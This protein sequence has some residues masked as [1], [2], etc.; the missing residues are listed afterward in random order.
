MTFPG[1]HRLFLSLIAGLSIGTVLA[2]TLKAADQPPNIVFFF[3][4]DQ[5]P[6]TLGCY[7][8]SIIQTPNIDALAAR[9]TR[10]DNAFVSQSICWVSRTTI[11]TGLTGRSYGT[12]GN[13]DLARADAVETFYTDILRQNGYRTGQFGK[14]HAKMAKGFIREAHFDEFEF[15]DR[16]PYFKTL[17]DGSLRHETDLVVDRGIDFVKRQ[18]DGQPFALNLWFNA[19]HAEDSDRRTAFG[20]YPWPPSTNGMYDDQTFERS[21]DA[22]K[23]F[24]TLPEIMQTTIGRER[25]FWRWDS[26]SKYQANMRAYYR[27]ISGIDHAIGR[28]IKT[29]EEQGLADNTIIIYTADN[30]YYM[31]RR[32]LAGK[33]SHFEESLRVPMIIMDP[34]QADH[35][36]SQASVLNLDLP[37]TILDYAGIEVPEKFEGQSLTGIVSGESDEGFRDSTF[38][39]HFAAR[40]R[41]PAFEGVRTDRWKYARYVDSGDEFLHDLKSDPG[42]TVNL[43]DDPSSAET[44]AEMRSKTDQYINSYGGPLQPLKGEMVIGTEAYPEAAVA[45]SQTVRED[46]TIALIDGKRLFKTWNGDPKFWSQKDG[47]ITGR[48]DGTLKRN[49]FITWMGNSVRNFELTMDVKISEGGNSGIQYRGTIQPQVGHDAVSGYQCDIVANNPRFNGML[50]EERGRRI[51]S[52]SGEK[53]VIDPDGQPWIIEKWKTQPAEPGQ[54]H[55]YKVIA[56]ANHLQHFIDGEKTVDVIDLDE[57][58]RSDDG[59]FG[60]QV[61]VGPKMEVQFKNILLKPL[62]DNLP[63]LLADEVEIPSGSVGVRPQMKLPKDWQPPVHP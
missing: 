55:Q 50:Y 51:V 1:I 46:G 15:I 54:W 45:V 39:E 30:G 28:M 52:R 40:N 61:H 5:N 38:H 8:N 53:I 36:V 43:V 18:K 41:L 20:V 57:N 32:G 9:G 44:L 59:V 48:A 60:M 19:G 47:V 27:M 13:H 31:G 14:W 4:D 21:D 26:D 62:P 24:A 37:S 6:S 58:G 2:P 22:A 34:R 10:F 23:I 56:K 3:A 33:W 49:H 11:L 12:P 42:E 17:E 29:L 63:N 7:G 16:N 25:F 35:R